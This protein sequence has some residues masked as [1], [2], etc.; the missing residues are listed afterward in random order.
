MARKPQTKKGTETVTVTT[1]A[2]DASATDTTNTA[3]AGANT[4]PAP[5]SIADAGTAWTE[6]APAINR[7][8]LASIVSATQGNSFVYTAE[9]DHAPLVAAGYA[10]VNPGMVDDNGRVA[11]RATK[12]G[13]DHMNDTTTNTAGDGAP[14]TGATDPNASTATDTTATAPAASASEEFA[15]FSVP[16]PEKKRA[17]VGGR[18]SS[19]PFDKLEV[20][21]SFFVANTA[22]RPNAKKS[23]AS[24][25]SS[26]TRRFA[27]QAKNEDGTPKMREMTVAGVKK[28]VPV[29]IENR[30]FEL[31]AGKGDAYGKPGVEGAIVARTK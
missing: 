10:E 18:S 30:K 22:E 31:Y 16:L 4:D 25:V 28:S 3:P 5:N 9:A 29:Y 2:A 26:A 21:Q 6:N 20:G 11:T 13:I 1:N 27:E 17:A 24:T 14:A 15:I 8:L 7:D 12:E 19:Y 23:L